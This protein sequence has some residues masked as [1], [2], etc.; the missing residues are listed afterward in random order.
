MTARGSHTLTWTIENQLA[1]YYDGSTTT[2]YV[3]DGNGQRGKKTVGGTTTLY[4]NKYYEKTGDTVTTSYYLGDRLV[5][6]TL[7]DW[8]LACL[9]LGHTPRSMV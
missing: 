8:I 1:S 7:E 9:K 3:Y 6:H 5:A 4:V 2:T